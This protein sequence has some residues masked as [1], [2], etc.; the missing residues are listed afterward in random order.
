MPVT[1]GVTNG[2]Q[3]EVSG[4]ELKPGM[5]LRDIISSYEELLPEP[6]L[7]QADIVRLV[8]P[9][10]HPK[11]IKF[12]L[13]AMLKGEESQNLPLQEMDRVIVYNAWEKKEMPEVTIKG[14]VRVPGKY[15]L[16]SGMTVASSAG[17]VI[18]TTLMT[19]VRPRSLVW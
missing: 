5:K 18:S 8:P 9:D 10:L 2:R 6:Y 11:I 15:R 17:S 12:D 16:Y 19:P 7:H 1:V 4:G 13:E 14:A 3:T